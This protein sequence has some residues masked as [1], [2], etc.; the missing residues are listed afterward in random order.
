MPKEGD[1][2]INTDVNNATQQ[3]GTDAEFLGKRTCHWTKVCLRGDLDRIVEAHHPLQTAAL[4]AAQY[5]ALPVMSLPASFAT[6]GLFLG[7]FLNVTI[8][9]VT[10]YTS[11]IAWYFPRASLSST[12]VC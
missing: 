3:L 1:L 6:L 5:I 10:F 2:Y 8:A 12:I 11:L 4:L 7:C 9:I